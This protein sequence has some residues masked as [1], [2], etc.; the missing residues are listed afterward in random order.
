MIA[1]TLVTIVTFAGF[2]SR[3]D[4]LD[5]G[6]GSRVATIYGKNISLPTAQRGMR[7]GELCRQ[8]AQMEMYRPQ[9]SMMDLYQA[10]AVNRQEAKENFLWNSMVLKHEADNLGVTV[11]EDEIFTAT[12]SMPSF[13]TNGVYDSSKYAMFA[14]NILPSMG[15][16]TDDLAELIGDSLRLQKVK[17]LLGST[18][19]P[20]DADIRENFIR[21][22]QKTDAQVVRFKID[23]FLASTQVPEEDVK[24]LYEERKASLKTD[25]Q[26]KV[27]F[28]AFVLPTT[29]K[30]LEGTARADALTKLQKQAEDFTVAMTDKTAKFDEVAAKDNVKVEESPDF[31]IAKPPEDLEAS[32]E[33]AAAVF[34]LTPQEPN[35]DVL[36]TARGYYVLQL[37]NVTPPRPLTFEEAKAELADT[38]KHERAQEA[39][40]VKASDVRNKIEAAVKAGKTFA[41]AAQELGVKA[42]DFPAFSPKEPKMDAPNAQEVMQ[43]T[44]DLGEGQVS[45]VEPSSDGSLIVYVAKREPIDENKLKADKG[46]L[47]ES[48]SEFQRAALFQQWLKLRRASAQLQ[49]SF[50]G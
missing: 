23:D 30:P 27:R 41:A 40:N 43:A 31:S 44:A 15:F 42:E 1:V 35:S 25:E 36:E 22:N 13:Q 46:Q 6:S 18:M 39:L 5:K 11:S 49:T 45:P 26:R 8:L 33:I 4:F 48:L 17:A 10:L 24:K 32:G 7:K 12:Q 50:R 3:S 20:S 21:L 28:V 16:T 37:V 34:K 14:Q 2:Y 19:A 9:H 29:D 38:L 47:A